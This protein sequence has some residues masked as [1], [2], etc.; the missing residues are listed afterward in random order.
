MPARAPP[1]TQQEVMKRAQKSRVPR[2]VLVLG[3]KIDRRDA[4][5]EAQLKTALGLHYFCTGK[6]VVTTII[7]I[8]LVNVTACTV[9]D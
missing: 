2:P 7:I 5:S 9:R 6:V 4:I 8:V 1:H 3:N